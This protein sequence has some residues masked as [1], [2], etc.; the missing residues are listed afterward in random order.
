[1]RLQGRRRQPPPEGWVSTSGPH[2][3]RRWADLRDG[4]HGGAKNGSRTRGK[5]A[6]SAD[7]A[8][9]SWRYFDP[10]AAN[11]VACRRDATEVKIRSFGTSLRPVSACLSTQRST[12]FEGVAQQCLK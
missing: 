2:R 5:M 9:S 3:D 1:M 8:I 6:L 10:T 11:L 7:A 12:V 4:I